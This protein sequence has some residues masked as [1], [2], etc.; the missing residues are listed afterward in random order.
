MRRML[1]S[2]VAAVLLVA[3]GG[4]AGPGT[5][6]ETAVVETLQGVEY[7]YACGN[8]I[9][10]L[11]DGRRFYPFIEQDRIDEEAY[12]GALATS[13]RILLMAA[14]LAVPAPEFGDDVGTLTI[15]EDGTARFV[16]D[17]GIEAWLTDEVQTYN[18]EC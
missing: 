1:M 5:G 15:Y 13:P 12:V 8:E 17:S 6:Q 9:L 4:A 7:Y 14:D 2:L 10:E 11:P 3:C 16:S 18:W